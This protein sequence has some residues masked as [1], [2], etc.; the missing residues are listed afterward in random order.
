MEHHFD[1]DVAKEYGVIEAVLINHFQFWIAKNKANGTNF[2]DGRHWTFNSQ[3]A[4]LE[5]FPYISRQSFRTAM[6]HLTDRGV[7][8][9][10]NYNETQY[11]R[12]SWYAFVDEDR[13]LGRNQP[14]H[15]LEST[16]GKAEINQPIPYNDTNNNP[17][18]SKD[19][20]PQGESATIEVVEV[21]E[22]D[23]FETAWNAYGK[24]GNKKAAK[25]YWSKLSAKDR[26]EIMETIPLYIAANPD[27]Q[28]RKDF[29]GWINPTY[30]RW[31][32]KIIEPSA[33]RTSKGSDIPEWM[34]PEGRARQEQMDNLMETIWN[35]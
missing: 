34:T 30:R 20:S 7:I 8:I 14:M 33:R 28:F 18:L 25:R 15:W 24:K 32:N 21:V 4:M 27:E 19:N 6:Q 2:H 9:I 31:E 10:G 13:W 23:G 35:S 11:D 5:L 29:S 1:I 3:K 17:P 12:T 22:D 26:K 16:N